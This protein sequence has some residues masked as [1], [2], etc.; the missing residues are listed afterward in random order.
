MNHDQNPPV[1]VLPLSK[2]G[3]TTVVTTSSHSLL[4][5]RPTC[6]CQ[7]EALLSCSAFPLR[8]SLP[9]WHS[10]G[11]PSPPSIPAQGTQPRGEAASA[12]CLPPVC[13]S[14]PKDCSRVW[15]L[16]NYTFPKPR[17]GWQRTAFVSTLKYPLQLCISQA[18]AKLS[19][20]MYEIC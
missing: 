2:W 13:E 1:P 8:M 5:V 11:M 19:I 6:G 16:G 15:F 7:M 12:K 9:A 17:K 10:S 3:V 20:P 14:A 18:E 4:W